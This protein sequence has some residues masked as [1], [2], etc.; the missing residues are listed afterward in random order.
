MS[1]GKGREKP[2]NVLAEKV[3]Y[4]LSVG[5]NIAV[6]LESLHLWRDC[7]DRGRESG[8]QAGWKP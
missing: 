4:S 6:V 5:S 2:T 7:A 1:E 3:L 8:M